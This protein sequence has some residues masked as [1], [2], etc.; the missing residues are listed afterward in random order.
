MEG[1]AAFA[2]DGADVGDCAWGGLAEEVAGEDS[3]EDKDSRMSDE[4]EVGRG[5]PISRGP[6]TLLCNL[7]SAARP[8][9]RQ[10][11]KQTLWTPF[12]GDWVGL[13]MCAPLAKG[14]S[15]KRA[16]LHSARESEFHLGKNCRDAGPFRARCR[17]FPSCHLSAIGMGT[18]PSSGVQ[19]VQFEGISLPPVPPPDL[20]TL[21]A[22]GKNGCPF[23]GQG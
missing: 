9:F 1:W 10:N 16:R 4:C 19:T 3:N 14:S 7:N 20:K 17:V 11:R 23:R 8:H 12:R 2:N 6:T 18:G 5:Y 15:A 13:V 21:H 22:L